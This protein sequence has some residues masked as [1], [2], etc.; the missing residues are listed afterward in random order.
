MRSFRIWLPRTF[1]PEHLFKVDIPC[2]HVGLEG[3]LI[4]SQ[5]DNL[6]RVHPNLMK[7]V[8]P[9]T[10][11]RSLFLGLTLL[12]AHAEVF[13]NHKGVKIKN[14]TF[15]YP[16]AFTGEDQKSYHEKAKRSDSQ[17]SP[18]LL[19]LGSRFRRL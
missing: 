7:R 19:W 18:V 6:W 15:T 17:D 16:L 2:L 12:Y 14:Y 10:P 8:H 3:P 13:F 9:K 11:W 4:N 5:L 1:K